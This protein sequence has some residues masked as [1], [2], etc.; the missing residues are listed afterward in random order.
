MDQGERRRL[1]ELRSVARR[2]GRDFITVLNDAGLLLTMERARQAKRDIILELADDLENA[3]IGAL[4]R[5]TGGNPSSALDA[6]RAIVQLLRDK[7]RRP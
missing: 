4:I 2:N 1:D 6:Q 7:G 3:S 5:R